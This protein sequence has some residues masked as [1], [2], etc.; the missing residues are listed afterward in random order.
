MPKEGEIVDANGNCAPVATSLPK[1][2]PA[3][4]IL[5]FIG[6]MALVAAVVYWYRSRMDVKRV[7]AG[8]SSV[9]DNIDHTKIEVV[10]RSKNSHE[11]GAQSKPKTKADK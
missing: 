2:G 10:S 1:T 6:L 9:E 7:L 4:A 8:V 3:E 11:S 5:S